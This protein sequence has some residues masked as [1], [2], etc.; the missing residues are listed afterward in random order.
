V[1]PALG[2]PRLSTGVSGR[3]RPR[4]AART[5]GGSGR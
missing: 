5:V 3:G 2:A 4:P 1:G